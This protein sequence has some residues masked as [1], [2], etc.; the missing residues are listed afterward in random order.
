MKVAVIIDTWFPA[1]GGG[2]INAYEISRH[3]AKGAPNLE[4]ITR[5]NGREDLKTPRNLKVTKLGP[6]ADPTNILSKIIF[7]IRAYFYVAGGKFDIVHVHAFLPGIIARLLMVTRGIPA[8]FTVHGTSIGTNLLN[9]L[10]KTI[11]KFILTEI[12]YSAQIT[13]AQDFKNLKNVNKNIFYIKNGVNVDDFDKVQA[14]KFKQPT[15]IF[16][17]RLHPQKNL[18]TLITAIGQTIGDFPQLKLLIVGE[19]QQKHE[20]RNLARELHLTKHIGFL[21]EVTGADLI[22]LYKSSHI[23]VLPSIYEGQPLTL[24]E[25]WSAKLPVIVTKTGDCQFLVKNSRNGYL[26]EDPN[27]PKEISKAVEIALKSPNLAHMGQN[28]YNLVRGNFSWG[29]TAQE[30]LRVYESLVSSQN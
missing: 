5:N 1:M 6:Y 13:V 20:L 15:L 28:G 25:A 22:K 23:F 21:G 12:L 11:E 26:I 10:A 2:Q 24:L 29:K 4:I 3:L 17:G 7:L 9:P 8:I 19:G 30:T 14:A 27:S 18:S 16:V